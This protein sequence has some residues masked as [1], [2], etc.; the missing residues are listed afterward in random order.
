MLRDLRR[1]GLKAVGEALARG[2]AAVDAERLVRELAPVLAP[3]WGALDRPAIE[4]E[5]R[6]AFADVGLE[7]TPDRPRRFELAP[8]R[9][10]LAALEAGRRGARPQAAPAGTIIFDTGVLP[11]TEG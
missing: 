4:A 9:E 1:W 5:L 2:D 6:R 10:R 3:A 11:A 7:A 8:L